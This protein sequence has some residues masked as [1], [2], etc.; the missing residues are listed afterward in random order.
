M[1]TIGTNRHKA[2]IQNTMLKV[3]TASSG[4]FFTLFFLI[5]AKRVRLCNYLHEN[6]EDPLPGFMIRNKYK[7]SLVKSFKKTMTFR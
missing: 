4:E 1:T 7:R 6:I 5:H 2:V 3:R